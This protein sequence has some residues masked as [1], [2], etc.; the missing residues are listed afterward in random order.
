MTS[1]YSPFQ[2][3]DPHADALAQLQKEVRSLRRLT[4]GAVALALVAAGTAGYGLVS[5]MP[6]TGQPAIAATAAPGAT[7]AKVPTPAATAAA[8]PSGTIVLGKADSGLPVLD[9]YEDYQ[10]PACAQVETYVASDIVALVASGKIEVRYHLMSFLDA[11]LG[12][13]ASVRA[14][15]G[16]FCA[17]EQ[18]KFLA[19]HDALFAEANRPKTEGDGWTDA[20]LA[21][22]AGAAGLDATSWGAC[23]ASGRFSSEVTDA[24]DLSLKA[25]VTGTPTYKLNGTTLNL[26]SV[27]SSGGLKAF[28][29][30]NA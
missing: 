27:M 6:R 18:G 21:K 1:P 15:N 14:A 19:W 8:A 16:G 26:N 13:D 22:L 20:Q 25:G 3:R 2:P 29:E 12:N 4:L 10:C 30:A 28:V 17:H 23:V 24:N 7:A 11:G 9:I 5:T